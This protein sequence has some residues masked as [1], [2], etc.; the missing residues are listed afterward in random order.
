MTRAEAWAANGRQTT[1][2]AAPRVQNVGS[3]FPHAA[4]KLPVSGKVEATGQIERR[5]AI[6]H[7]VAFG[8][9]SAEKN[10]LLIESVRRQLAQQDLQLAL[11]TAPIKRWDD[12]QKPHNLRPTLD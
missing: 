2:F 8:R 4:A 7:G 5:E 9:A 12:M 11:G 10:H 1:G 6:G 3:Q